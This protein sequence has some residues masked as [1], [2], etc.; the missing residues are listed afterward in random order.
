M[1]K[2]SVTYDRVR[3]G[4]KK[5]RWK[6]L[7]ASVRRQIDRASI[8]KGRWR[9]IVVHNS[10]TTKGNMRAF[11][12]YHRNVKGMSNGMAYHF[13]IGN[14]SYTGNGQVEIGNRW[15][16]QI[17]GG[18]LRSFAQNQIA[19]GICLV[20]DFNSHRVR[21]QQLESLDELIAYLQ[22]KCG[23]AIVT[24]HRRINIRPTSCPGRY[25]PD[26]KVMTAY[27]K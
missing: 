15:T 27:N 9:Y 6:Y 23:K 12:R 16:R 13:V 2:S 19:I 4:Q 20:G 3:L 8:R 10:A 21:S 26:R 14:G 22:A 1:A 7:N 5:P 11:D 25:F 17:H 24:T 18:H